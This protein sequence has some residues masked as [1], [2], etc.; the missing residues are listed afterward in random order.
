[1]AACVAAGAAAGWLI[2]GCEQTGGRL[3]GEEVAPEATEPRGG[4][5]AR[6]A[7]PRRETPAAAES[8]LQDK[9]TALARSAGIEGLDGEGLRGLEALMKAWFETS[10][11]EALAW[12]AAQ[13]PVGDRHFY[14][15]AILEEVQN[16]DFHAA[17]EFI[18]TYLAGDGLA[19]EIPRPMLE[20]AGQE[21]AE[22]LLRLLTA[23]TGKQDTGSGWSVDFPA[24]FDFQRLMDGLA[25]AEKNLPFGYG[26]TTY[27]ANVVEEWTN[28]RPQEAYNWL[29]SADSNLI[30]SSMGDFY[31]AYAPATGAAEYGEFTRQVHASE[32]DPEQA[33]KSALLALASKPE[34]GVMEEFF[35][36]FPT[37]RREAVLEEIY[38]AAVGRQGL[39]IDTTRRLLLK[40]MDP[41][42]MLEFLRTQD[43]KQARK[44]GVPGILRSMGLPSEEVSE[45]FPD[46]GGD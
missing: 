40:Q 10:P 27:P 12:A 19:T 45:L 24:D 25:D 16:E 4:R 22:M 9:I 15:E 42:R 18:E 38:H 1:M 20:R 23:S 17:V 31:R 3:T 29:K 7:G 44:D 43:A 35:N 14:L 41:A 46:D 33:A 6:P 21:G 26:L 2:R 11:Q 13:Q 32:A 30:H 28:A 37:G 5:V 36:G 8:D 39:G 34:S